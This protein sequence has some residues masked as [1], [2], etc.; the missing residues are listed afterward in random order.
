M[1]ASPAVGWGLETDSSA[2]Q[3]DDLL[4]D[5]ETE[6][7]ATLSTA[8]ADVGLGE[9]LE[10]ARLEVVRNTRAMIADGDAHRVAALRDANRH[11][12]ARRGEFDGIGK[13]IGDDL[14]QPVGIG[15][16]HCR[17]RGGIELDPY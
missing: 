11:F 16:H 17:R 3:R 6:T 15:A 1:E 13:Q 8:L 4:D 10:Y 9:F 2:Q 12:G 14:R 5:A 7:G